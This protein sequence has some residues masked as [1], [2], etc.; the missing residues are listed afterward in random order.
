MARRTRLRRRRSHTSKWRKITV[1]LGVLLAVGIVAGG[2]AGGWAVNVYESAPPL[3]SLK[4]V[5]KGRS[6]A[7]YAADGSLIGF[8]QAENIRQPVPGR[9]MPQTLRDA[10]VAIEDRNFFNHGA[11]DPAGIARAAWKD[12]LAGGKPVQGASTIT[13]QLVRNL[14]IQ[15]PEETLKRKLIEAQDRK[16][17]V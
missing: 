15:N 8:I 13:Q 3:S 10:T 7:I 16:S 4:P 14:Y 6:S 11:L 5:Q 2:V 17:V 12:L 9:T 1:P